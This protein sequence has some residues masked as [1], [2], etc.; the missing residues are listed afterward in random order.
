MVFSLLFPYSRRGNVIVV[1]V[2][3]QS[4]SFWSCLNFFIL[5]S[6]CKLSNG[7][8]QH[9]Y[10]TYCQLVQLKVLR[11]QTKSCL[12]HIFLCINKVHFL[13]NS[14]QASVNKRLATVLPRLPRLGLVI[15]IETYS[16]CSHV[17][18]CYFY[19]FL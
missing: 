3:S 11:G 9:A 4:F 17:Q 15:K 6:H 10:F 7:L 14:S 5:F 18:P 8:L 1:K 13:H 12:N 19:C 16:M 2:Y